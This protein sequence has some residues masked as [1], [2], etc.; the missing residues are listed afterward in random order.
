[1]R[2][3]PALLPPRIFGQGFGFDHDKSAE[4]AKRV[5]EKSGVANPI[6]R[7]GLPADIAEAVLYL[8]SDAASFVTGTHLTVDGGITIGPRHS[9]DPNAPRMMAEV[10]GLSAEQM[11]AIRQAAMK[12]KT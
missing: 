12:P 2:L 10:M 4:L 11:A 1:M 7:S 6:G 5:A 3:S 9:W 8:C